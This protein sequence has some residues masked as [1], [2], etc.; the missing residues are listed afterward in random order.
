MIRHVA[1][2]LGLGAALLTAACATTTPTEHPIERMGEFDLN[3]PKKKLSFTE[4]DSDTWG[5][6][7]CGRRIKYVRVCRQTGVGVFVE[8]E[9]RWVAN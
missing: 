9:C 7:G 8:D 5:V 1:C 6:T 2:M 4:I 3:C